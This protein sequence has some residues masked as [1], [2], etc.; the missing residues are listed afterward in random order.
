M[1]EGLGPA[2]GSP[3]RALNWQRPSRDP[4]SPPLLYERLVV[5]LPHSREPLTPTGRRCREAQGPSLHPSLL[6]RRGKAQ[7]PPVHRPLG[8]AVG[9]GG[10]RGALDQT[11]GGVQ[12]GTRWGRAFLYLKVTRKQWDVLE[13]VLRDG[14]MLKA[15]FNIPFKG[16]TKWFA[17]K[18][19]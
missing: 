2:Q 17:L 5:W 7:A 18:R 3:V 10:R 13:M 4:A 15:G 1:V 14:K 9:Q 6:P 8:M 16:D 12:V 11:S 19:C